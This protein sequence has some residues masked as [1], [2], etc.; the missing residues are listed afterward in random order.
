MSLLEAQLQAAQRTEDAEKQSLK[1]LVVR[2]E[3]KLE[4]KHQE[5]EQQLKNI[6][7]EKIKLKEVAK[8]LEE[9]EKKFQVCWKY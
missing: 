1:H 3:E 8:I 6:Q 9:K 5:M 7:G 4:A 2:L